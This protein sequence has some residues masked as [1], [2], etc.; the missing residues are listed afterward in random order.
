MNNGDTPLHQ[1]AYNGHVETAEFLLS[2]GAAVD[3]KRID[4]DTPLH[5]AAWNGHVEAA[6][7]LLSKGAAVDA[8]KNNGNTPLHMATC[9]GHVKAAELLLSKGATVDANANDGKT[10]LHMATYNGHVKAAELLL[11]KG[12]AVDAKNDNGK[13]PLHA[14]SLNGQV[15]AAELLLSK[16]A[17]VDAKSKDGKTPLDLAR[18]EG[19]TKMVQFLRNPPAKKASAEDGKTP[20][21]LSSKGKAEMKPL[22]TAADKTSQAGKKA[23]QTPVFE[24]SSPRRQTS[25]EEAAPHAAGSGAA[26]VKHQREASKEEAKKPSAG[27]GKAPVADKASEEVKK[28]ERDRA[29]CATHGGGTTIVRDTSVVEI[30]T[31]EGTPVAMFSARFDGGPTEQ[32]M[33]RVHKILV[34]NSYNALMVEVDA[35]ESFGVLT[36]RYLGQLKADK[37]LMIAVCTHHYG[38]MTSSEFCSFYELKFAVTHGIK[39]LPLRVEDTYPPQPPCGNNHLDKHR[40][41]LGF[42]DMKIGPDVLYVDCRTMSEMDIACAIATR[43]RKLRDERQVP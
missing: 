11:S 28:V 43:L 22:P 26:A 23:Q 16:G 15:A 10:P 2:K 8:T 34:D 33:R 40:D 3:A 4:G 41:A 29:P 13:T 32:K 42:I 14:A 18:E 12:A 31:G 1:A 38:E 21:D 39:V 20:A 6:E 37:G 9:N 35:G 17:A 30:P 5:L 7:F 36:A 24:F 19:K 27:D 25:K